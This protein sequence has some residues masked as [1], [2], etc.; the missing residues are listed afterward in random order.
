MSVLGVCVECA[1]NH[2]HRP[3]PLSAD[4]PS[5][6]RLRDRVCLLEVCVLTCSVGVALVLRSGIALNYYLLMRHRMPDH[7]SILVSQIG[8]ASCFFLWRLIAGTYG[9]YHYLVY[10][11]AFLPG[12]FPDSRAQALSVALVLA[13][14]LQWFWGVGIIKMA[15]RKL[16]RMEL[17]ARE[18]LARQAMEDAGKKES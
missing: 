1:D 8:F 3:N 15:S 7:I 16:R 2:C 14:G 11:K 9:T 12:E 6:R 18:A 5:E 4:I 13:G 17:L 10:S